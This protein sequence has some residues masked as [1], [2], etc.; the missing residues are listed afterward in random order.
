MIY[1]RDKADT[2]YWMSFDRPLNITPL[3]FHIYDFKID[4]KIYTQYSE[5]FQHAFDKELTWQRMKA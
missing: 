2:R 3:D 1:A 5:L 4:D